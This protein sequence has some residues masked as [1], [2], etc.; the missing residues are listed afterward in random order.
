MNKCTPAGTG[1]EHTARNCSSLLVADHGSPQAVYRRDSVARAVPAGPAG[2][3]LSAL[4][5]AV[6]VML[7]ACL[8]STV[9]AHAGTPAP[10]LAVDN[11]VATAGFY[12]LSWVTEAEQAELQEA[13]DPAFHDPV[14]LYT[15][16]DRASVL[17]GKPD[18]TRYYRVRG[19]TNATPGR[20]SEPV[21]VTVEHHDLRRA[22]LFLALGFSVFVAILVTVVRGAS[23]A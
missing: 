2:L 4:W 19:I 5:M 17:S 10:Q 14:T 21:R 7:L 22:F 15:G 3:R 16:P 11:P 6:R 18:G 12:R 8:L 23:A 9:P 13:T 1:P 20:W